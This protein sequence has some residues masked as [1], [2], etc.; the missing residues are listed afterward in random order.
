MSLV[1]T[2]GD[3]TE[4]ALLAAVAKLGLAYAELRQA[5]PRVAELPFDSGRKR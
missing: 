2:V 1:E 3:P 5:W 4:A